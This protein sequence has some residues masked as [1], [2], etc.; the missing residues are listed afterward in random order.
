[1]TYPIQT[2]KLRSLERRSV[3]NHR[4]SYIGIYGFCRK[5]ITKVI[6]F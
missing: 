3:V 6:H 2:V 1:M 5:A 4:L